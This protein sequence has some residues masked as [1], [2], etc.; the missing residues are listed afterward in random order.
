MICGESERG[1]L[2]APLFKQRTGPEVLRVRC[3][4][5]AGV[6]GKHTVKLLRLGGLRINVFQLKVGIQY[7]VQFGRGIFLVRFVAG[8]F[9]VKNC[10]YTQGNNH[11]QK[12]LSTVFN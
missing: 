2:V 11:G 4:R 3:R 10:P 5:G 7:G 1:L 12:H 9:D 6:V 8:L